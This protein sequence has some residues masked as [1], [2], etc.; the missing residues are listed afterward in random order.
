M[1][2][3]LVFSGSLATDDG[4]PTHEEQFTRSRTVHTDSVALVQRSLDTTRAFLAEDPA[5]ARTSLDSLKKLTPPLDRELDE[6]FGSEMINLDRAFHVTID[7]SREFAT[8]GRQAEAFDQFVWVQRACIKC[9]GLAREAGR[10]PVAS[11]TD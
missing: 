2:L 3:L 8:A 5:A 6:P 4:V 9:H 1:S 10:L 11:A 7:R